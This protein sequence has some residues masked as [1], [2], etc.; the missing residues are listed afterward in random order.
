MTHP[1]DSGKTAAALR[2]LRARIT[3]GEWTLNS[4]IPREHE[5][6]VAIGVG[7]S[8][9][10][11][12]VRSLT[13]LG[14]LEPIRGVGTFVRSRTPVN[15]VIADYIADFPVA[16]ILGYRRSL[17]IESARQAAVNR[18]EEQL[19]TLTALLDDSRNAGAESTLPFSHARA[20]GSFHHTVVEASGN[21]LLL[22]MY[23]CTIAAVRRHRQSGDLQAPDLPQLR[24]EDH[25]V[26]LRA[27][28]DRDPDAAAA[29]MAAHV[30]HDITP[31][32]G[33][34]GPTG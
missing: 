25:S 21:L 15:S 29:A 10:R 34:V 8:T 6:M 12:A 20:P 3:S 16:D 11:E 27:I 31:D 28:R 9:L 32:P 5:L 33:A 14:M 18:S 19:Q 30:S 17:E 26:I 4:R 22:N 23:T 13:S 2:Y 7:K 24:R 1:T